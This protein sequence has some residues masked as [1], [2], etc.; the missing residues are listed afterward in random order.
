[1]AKRD[2]A[3]IVANQLVKSRRVKVTEHLMLLLVFSHDLPL[4]LLELFLNREDVRV[5]QLPRCDTH[6]L[7]DFH[8]FF[9]SG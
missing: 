1:M 2:K 3:P 5:A 4:N 8:G 7:E 6:C 9:G